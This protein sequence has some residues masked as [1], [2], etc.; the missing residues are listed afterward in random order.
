MQKRLIYGWWLWLV[1]AVFYSLD[2]FQHTAPSVLIKPIAHSAHISFIDV[3]TI[4]SLYF[5][6]YAISQLPAGYLLDRFGVR[7]VLSIACLVVTAGLFLTSM[8]AESTLVVGRILIA[9]G[10]AFAFL[11]ALKTAAATLNQKVF[12]IA[13]GL[14]NTIGVLGGILGQSFFNELILRFDWEDA[15]HLIGLFGIVLA[16]FLFIFLRIPK[17]DTSVNED[18]N[19][20]CCQFKNLGYKD[21]FKDYKVWL[22]AIYAGI[23]VG[24]VVNAFS[25]LYD[26]SFLEGVFR[27]GSEQAALISSMVFIGIAVGG[28][29]HG[30]IARRFQFN[31]TWMLIGCLATI[32]VFACIILSILTSINTWVLFILYFLAGFFVS[33]MLLSFSVA[34]CCYKKEVHATIF[35]LVNMVIGVCGF[36]FQLLLGLCLGWLLHTF[37]KTDQHTVYFIGFLVLMVPLI[38]S[39]ICCTQIKKV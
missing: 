20:R 21:L 3:G 14:T 13:V 36:V 8:P 31:K 35:A 5:P 23:M 16:I 30:P 19:A 15:L 22:L 32:I 12:P 37:G 34:R 11:G 4:M 24:T 29:L 25:E 6:I 7:Y 26:V 1:A 27:M 2:Y 28:P 10:S 17:T 39:F 38:I 18:Y 33:S 9:C